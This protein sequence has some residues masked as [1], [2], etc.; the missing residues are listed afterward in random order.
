MNIIKIT[1]NENGSRPPL[2]TWSKKELPSGFAWCP[3]EFAEVFY[4]TSPAGFVDIV[5]ENDSVTEMVVN[6]EALTA[7]IAS[8]PE[9]DDTLPENDSDSSVYDELAEAYME[10]VNSIDK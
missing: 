2:Q 5:V 3:D 9:V 8:L 10:G 7:Y 6:Q 4:G 1:A